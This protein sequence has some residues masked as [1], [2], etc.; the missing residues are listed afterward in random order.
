[1]KVWNSAPISRCTYMLANQAEPDALP[2][3]ARRKG[4]WVPGATTQC[5]PSNFCQSA[6]PLT[7]FVSQLVNKSIEVPTTSFFCSVSSEVLI[8]P[9]I[10]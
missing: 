3:T 5:L 6:V 4:E 8:S 2:L 7:D 10:E 1:M 9:P